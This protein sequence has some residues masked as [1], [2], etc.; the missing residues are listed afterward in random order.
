LIR[1]HIAKV[2]IS[3]EFQQKSPLNF[4]CPKRGTRFLTTKN[5]G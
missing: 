1:F 2:G 3:I 4:Y 5:G